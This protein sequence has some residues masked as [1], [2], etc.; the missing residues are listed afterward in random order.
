MFPGCTHDQ[1][2]KIDNSVQVLAPASPVPA[3]TAPRYEVIFDPTEDLGL[4]S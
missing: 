4:A 2:S 1:R 3:Y